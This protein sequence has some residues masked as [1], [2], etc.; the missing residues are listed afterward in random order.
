[1][2]E[3]LASKREL[4][5]NKTLKKLSKFDAV[6]IDDNGVKKYFILH[7]KDCEWRYGK[8]IKVLEKELIKIF[9]IY[10]KEV[11]DNHGEVL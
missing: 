8:E 4:T 9:K 1:V 7:L 6:I 5:L 11:L 10:I 3:L 2:Q